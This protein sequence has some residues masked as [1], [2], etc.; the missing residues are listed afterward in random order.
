MLIVVI[1]LFCSLNIFSSNV[2]AKRPKA[3]ASMTFRPDFSKVGKV[4]TD[5]Q[6]IEQLKKKQ[7]REE[8]LR[9]QTEAQK[10]FYEQFF[11][12]WNI[13][14]SHF[15]HF[16]NY[17]LESKNK[18]A[19]NFAQMRDNDLQINNN[20]K[21]MNTLSDQ[22]AEIITNWENYDESEQEKKGIE[23]EDIG[24]KF[25]AL[26]NKNQILSDLNAA[27]IAENQT[28]KDM[29]IKSMNDAARLLTADPLNNK[30]SKSDQ[31][32]LF[33]GTKQQ[34]FV[35]RKNKDL[36]SNEQKNQEYKNIKEKLNIQSPY[37]V[38]TLSDSPLQSDRL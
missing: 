11:K 31:D 9:R 30:L 37:V 5:S 34:M 1:M 8:A 20:E 24:V 14:V 32:R 2:P 18:L 36:L 26:E 16:D 29:E 15:E 6:E 21:E 17:E 19:D 13:F 3:P 28:I 25:A 33:Q 23:A 35:H 22:N 4:I 7:A 12:E 10:E 27:L 38:I